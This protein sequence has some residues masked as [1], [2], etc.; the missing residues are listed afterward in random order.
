MARAAM[1][2]P[3]EIPAL[4]PV[5]RPEESLAVTGGRVLFVADAAAAAAVPVDVGLL[6]GVT[7]LGRLVAEV[8]LELNV[9]VN[10][11]AVCATTVVD[12]VLEALLVLLDEAASLITK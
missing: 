2:T 10:V 8:E 6:L 1:T 12:A 4:A 5:P 11:V 7:E 3:T 9:L